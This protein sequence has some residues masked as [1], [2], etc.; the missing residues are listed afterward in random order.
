MPHKLTLT[1]L[2]EKLAVC[3]LAADAP[4]PEWA[5][6]GSFFAVTRTSDEVSIVVPQAQAPSDVRQEPDFRALKVAGPLDF[7]AVGVLASLTGPLA[8]AGIS[9]FALSTF[10]TD[11][12][13]VRERDL[14]HALAA[15]RAAGHR[16]REST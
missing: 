3:R 1:V 11:Y 14:P 16:A 7:S 6:Q 4:V 10:D 9:L 8:E 2:P 12:V 13:L 5:G 15:L